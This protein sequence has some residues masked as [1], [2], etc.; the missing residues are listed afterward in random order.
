MTMSGG[1]P[2]GMPSPRPFDEPFDPRRWLFAGLAALFVLIGIAIFLDVAISLW[3]GQLPSRSLNS[4]P[5]D[6]IIG[7]IGLLIAIWIVFWILRMIFWG[8]WG[9]PYY[10]HRW[11]HYDRRYHWGGPFGSDPAVDI[12][13]ERYARGEITQE[14]FEKIMEQLGKGSGPL[15]P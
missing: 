5:W 14:Q 1:P 6:W 12:A 11:R 15:P 3:R 9:S 8:L 7:V 10:A 2:T 13:R 4:D